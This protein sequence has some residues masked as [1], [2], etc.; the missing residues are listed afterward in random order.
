MGSNKTQS[1]IAKKIRN[2]GKEG[3]GQK[4]KKKSTDLTLQVT[5]AY[6]R[7]GRYNKNKILCPVLV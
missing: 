5:M 4:D 6:L 1:V 3:K 7:L 2:K